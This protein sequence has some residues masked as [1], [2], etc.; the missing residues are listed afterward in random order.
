MSDQNAPESVQD[1]DKLVELGVLHS[2]TKG[3]IDS[4]GISMTKLLPLTMT[5]MAG[6]DPS[7]K[8]Y[9]QA[10]NVL[11]KSLHANMALAEL[12]EKHLPFNDADL[13]ELTEEDKA[14]LKADVKAHP[15]LKE[16]FKEL[17]ESEADKVRRM[18]EEIKLM[19]E[20]LSRDAR[21]N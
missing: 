13:A 19:R 12:I 9:D 2:L 1:H 21:S 20:Q 11:V 10:M 3:I 16:A 7:P 6:Q 14:A 15:I 5:V 18:N 8:E 17:N 4:V